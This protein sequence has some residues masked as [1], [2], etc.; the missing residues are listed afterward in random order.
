MKKFIILLLLITL[1]APVFAQNFPNEEPPADGANDESVV[2]PGQG[3]NVADDTA[4]NPESE[5]AIQPPQDEVVV[6]AQ[7]APSDETDAAKI[8]YKLKFAA[9]NSKTER[10]LGGVSI[11]IDENGEKT[12]QKLSDPPKSQNGEELFEATAGK[13]EIVASRAGYKNYEGSF[14]VTDKDLGFT[15]KMVPL[16]TTPDPK[17]EFLTRYALMQYSMANSSTQG[18]PYAQTNPYQTNPTFG[19][20]NYGSYGY[21]TYTQNGYALSANQQ[22]VVPLAVTISSTAMLSSY[23]SFDVQII[24][25]STSSVVS[26][27]NSQT[28]YGYSNNSYTTNLNFYNS[29]NRYGCLKS[30]SPYILRI[31]QSPLGSFSSNTNQDYPFRSSSYG[32]ITQI[33]IQNITTGII[34]SPITPNIQN[35]PQ[36]NIQ[37][38]I[39][40]PASYNPQT[41]TTS[42]PSP[43]YN[44]G[45]QY[46]SGQTPYGTTTWADPTVNTL[47]FGSYEVQQS[48]Q[49]SGYFLVNKAVFNDAR[50]IQ[51][52][53]NDSGSGGLAFVSAQSG[54]LTGSQSAGQWYVTTYTRNI[55]THVNSCKIYLG[56]LTALA[57]F[58]ELTTDLQTNYRNQINTIGSATDPKAQYKTC[59]S[60]K[61]KLGTELE[62]KGASL[63]N[64]E[65]PSTDVN[66]NISK[67]YRVNLSPSEYAR[68]ISGQVLTTFEQ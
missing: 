45:Y 66:V 58:K 41:Q 20:P 50:I 54:I 19:N 37:I 34:S 38:P 8:K 67:F 33:N 23:Q 36:G 30:N 63:P 57:E 35:V 17:T 27:I 12:D 52:V 43:N 9:I 60:I 14:E 64:F 16:S 10:L 59:M 28:P 18:F 31:V 32:T 5:G 55:S 15:L 44:P 47:N 26:L 1:P 39:N 53:E 49:R 4:P 25:L 2:A 22:A 51:F 61:N 6:P 42:W 24:D 56:K 48:D 11:V 7:Q 29:I 21:P 62:G 65:Y 40:C 68:A 3:P 13:Y 46:P